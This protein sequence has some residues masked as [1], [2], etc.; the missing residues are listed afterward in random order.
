MFASRMQCGGDN[1]RFSRVN[2]LFTKDLTLVISCRR[3]WNYDLF[4]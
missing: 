1:A 3:V 4:R 2:L